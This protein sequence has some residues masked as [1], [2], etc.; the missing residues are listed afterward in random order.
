MISD[1]SCEND[2]NDVNT[3]THLFTGKNQL[4]NSTFP[5]LCWQVDSSEAF[6]DVVIYGENTLS[7]VFRVFWNEAVEGSGVV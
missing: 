3:W 4:T 2:V 6:L 1:L 7:C 5:V